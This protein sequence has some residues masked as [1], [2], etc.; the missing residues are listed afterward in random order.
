MAEE[1]WNYRN[2]RWWG[3]WKSAPVWELAQGEGETASLQPVMRL[4]D[5]WCPDC[6]CRLKVLGQNEKG[7][8]K[9]WTGAFEAKL[10]ESW[11][12]EEMA[13]SGY[14]RIPHVAKSGSCLTPDELLRLNRRA[15]DR[16]SKRSVQLH[17]EA[18]R[19]PVEELWKMT[20]SYRRMRAIGYGRE[21]NG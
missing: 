4:Q 14:Y 9:C 17:A 6:G 18:M 15:A 19:K 12:G 8:E 10:I 7:K 11:H 20:K 3:S 2:V 16:L 21:E 5:G 1:L 13:G